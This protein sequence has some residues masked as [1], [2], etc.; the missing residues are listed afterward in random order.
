M[1]GPR[2]HRWSGRRRP[3]RRYA[4]AVLSLSSA[5]VVMAAL[6]ATFY[7]GPIDPFF[8][9]VLATFGLLY[10]GLV[11]VSYVELEVELEGD[12]MSVSVKEVVGRPIRHR[13]YEL[14]RGEVR[15]VRE[16]ALWGVAETVRVEGDDGRLLAIFPRFLEGDEHD[17]MI[18]AILEWGGQSPLALEADAR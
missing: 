6:R 18:A 17:G 13:A 9:A 7:E 14:R 5:L 11:L 10:F 15:K 8:M 2:G 4:V 3:S 16:L 1:E 12:V